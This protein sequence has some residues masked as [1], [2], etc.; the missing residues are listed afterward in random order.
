MEFQENIDIDDVDNAMGAENDA[1]SVST[2]QTTAED[3]DPYVP[4][5]FDLGEL[6]RYIDTPI[7]ETIEESTACCLWRGPRGSYNLIP[8]HKRLALGSDRHVAGKLRFFRNGREFSPRVLA[9]TVVR[10]DLAVLNKPNE[11]L[12]L[13]S[14][15]KR[16]N[17][18][19]PWH[20]KRMPRRTVARKKTPK[21]SAK[22][23]KYAFKLSDYMRPVNE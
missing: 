17:C 12:R 15:C 4:R 2:P 11:R 21:S 14:T 1:M 3:D 5:D 8:E 22:P 20:Q 16:Y 6:M 9:F 19:N 10:P 18:I 23:R 13:V 7:P